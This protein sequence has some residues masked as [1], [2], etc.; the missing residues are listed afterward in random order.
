MIQINLLPDIKIVYLKVR[1]LRI[2]VFLVAL[3]V[4]TICTIA[5]L[6]LG[7]TALVHQ[8]NDILSHQ[9]K[10]NS[11][12]K[13]FNGEEGR[14]VRKYLAIQSK[15]QSL[16]QLEEEKIDAN[17]IWSSGLFGGGE[18]SFLP[19]R[20]LEEIELY[21]FNFGTGEFTISGAVEGGGEDINFRDHFLHAYY[22]TKQTDEN[23]QDSWSCPLAP[24]PGGL[25]NSPDWTY[26]R[27]FSDVEANSEFHPELDA[28]RKITIS[29]LFTTEVP[30]TG[31][32][33][34]AKDVEM[35]VKVPSGCSDIAC[36]TQPDPGENEPQDFVN[37]Q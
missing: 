23:G 4:I 37:T 16:N 34:F 17:R 35:Q 32:N 7:V 9:K 8:K 5:L 27:M 25:D 33:L 20:Y 1:R 10:I 3:F 36:I 6:L 30:G 11:Y 18:R 13:S 22:E 29:G 14:D 19:S 21:D 12:V 15:F 31:T 2:I 26:C 28:Q 24:P